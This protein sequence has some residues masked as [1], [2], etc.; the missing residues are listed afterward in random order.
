MIELKRLKA[1]LDACTQTELKIL[2]Y[3]LKR[4]GEDT[5][6]SVLL[7]DLQR[8]EMSFLEKGEINSKLKI[9]KIAV[10]KLAQR[11][12][13]KVLDILILKDSIL[14]NDN[15]DLRA[16]E[17]FGLKKKLLQFE[18]LSLKGC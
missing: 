15:Y 9:N 16:I 1:I 3:Y 8:T 10:K 17:I 4:N 7:G 13:D 6:Y 5:K 12:T 2:I 18:M 11:L 14:S